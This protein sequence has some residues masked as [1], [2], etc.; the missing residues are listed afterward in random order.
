M[1]YL[2][3]THLSGVQ[4]L[5][6]DIWISI[7]SDYLDKC[8]LSSL[9]ST[10]RSIR[11]DILPILFKTITFCAFDSKRSGSLAHCTAYLKY[12]LRRIEALI[13]DCK[14]QDYIRRIHLQNFVDLPHVLPT[15]DGSMA[16]DEDW[17][18][19]G[20]NVSQE[21]ALELHSLRLTLFTQ[22]RKLVFYL[23]NLRR[24]M[25]S[26]ESFYSLK[27]FQPST[28]RLCSSF[29][30]IKPVSIMF[31]IESSASFRLVIPRN[32][33]LYK[34][35]HTYYNLETSYFL[36]LIQGLDLSIVEA[37]LH[38][39][40][41]AFL[42]SYTKLAQPSLRRLHISFREFDPFFEEVFYNTLWQILSSSPGIQKLEVEDVI[43]GRIRSFSTP[44]KFTSHITSL[45]CG[46]HF[47]QELDIEVPI[48][49]LCLRLLSWNSTIQNQLS[50]ISQSTIVIVTKLD[51]GD[52]FMYSL[53]VATT[54]ATIF[55]RLEALVI[56]LNPAPHQNTPELIIRDALNSAQPF[57]FLKTLTIY[58]IDPT[59][60]IPDD[61]SIL[62]DRG[63]P[64][65]DQVFLAE[66][67]AFQWWDG[68]GWIYKTHS[69]RPLPN[70]DGPPL[71]RETSLVSTTV[72]NFWERISDELHR[73]FWRS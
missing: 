6:P 62:D 65:L 25:F 29:R 64:S 12:S 57:T 18:W 48:P 9:S 30:A 8:D 39:R 72:W 38:S 15:I 68:R 23:P 1:D 33:A 36:D 49:N 11:E 14:V 59:L 10:C 66:A 4:C 67:A 28:I 31:V 43:I 16:T 71:K 13:L 41:I 19:E 61:N 50:S 60:E 2:D 5:P 45:T 24:I 3:I 46:I 44:I 73:R 17:R 47:L 7:A 42:P 55:P 37:Y 35:D 34:G 40:L 54:I 20:H 63:H 22:I 70:L 26:E 69:S 52:Y 32:I 21:E 56:R 58:G 27:L 51:L 53:D